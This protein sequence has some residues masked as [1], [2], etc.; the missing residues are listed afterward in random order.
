[1]D[2]LIVT[3]TLEG[4]SNHQLRVAVVRDL[5]MP[6]A[7]LI[8]IGALALGFWLWLPQ[9]RFLVWLCGAGGAAALGWGVLRVRAL[10]AAPQDLARRLDD[11]ADAHDLLQT[12]MAVEARRAVGGAAAQR[13]VLERSRALLPALSEL[14]RPPIEVPLAPIVLTAMAGLFATLVIALALVVPVLPAPA[15]APSS[16]SGLPHVASGLRDEVREDLVAAVEDLEEL[17][18]EPGLDP[19]A[20]AA[21]ERARD[22][23]GSAL[24]HLDD[25]QRAAGELDR[26]RTAI[27]QAQRG[28]YRSGSALAAA[29]SDAVTD[30]MDRALQRGDRAGARRLADEVLRRV[31]SERSEGELRRLG[32]QLAE[33]DRPPGAAG[34]AMEKAGQKLA[35][36]DRGGALSALADLMAELGEPV[37]YIER[38]PELRS[39]AEAIERARSRALE[40]LEAADRAKDGEGA[41][42]SQERAE[43][44]AVA[45]GEGST[46]APVDLPQG[47]RPE[48]PGGGPEDGGDKD[49]APG[50]SPSPGEPRVNVD[51]PDP[52]APRQQAEGQ[53]SRTARGD[54]ASVGDGPMDGPG[55][56]GDG[57][58]EGEG[59]AGEGEGTSG[60][61]T[62]AGGAPGQGAGQ[63]LGAGASLDLPVTDLADDV[64]DS[65]WVESQWS[66]SPERMGELMRGAEAG[67]RSS[68]TWSEVHARYESIAESASRRQRVPMSRRTFIQT[69]FE[70]IRPELDPENP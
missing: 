23:A 19:S 43:G 31:E 36:G 55:G 13:E 61:M 8:A 45:P 28:P 30:A 39:A 35:A 14:G 46:P 27:T 20:K 52:D 42:T 18:R 5:S 63:G 69:Y 44:P 40:Q 50:G 11:R 16:G 33:R 47:A 54:G 67:G 70:A 68:L 49:L 48:D 65:E 21:V 58:P 1:M 64:V 38:P 59:L 4:W 29:A 26:A 17:A 24:T 25:A 12:A 7:V 37:E 32:R 41:G 2:E 56:R 22:A 15:P 10:R 53:G 62:A 66:A 51:A 6:I 57:A 9:A 60:S 34:Y 3:R